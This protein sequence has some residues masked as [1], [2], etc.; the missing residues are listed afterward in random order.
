MASPSFKRTSV[1]I[2]YSHIDARFFDQLVEHLAYFERNN[3]LKV[4]SD[5]KIT[6]GAQWREEI[7]QA[8]EYTAVAV[9]LIS[10]SYL[11]SMFIADNELPPLLH[12]AEKEGAIILPVLV[13]SSYFEDTEL[14]NFQA[15]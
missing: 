5:K 15:V 8:I 10:P 4:W 13:R 3:L 11:A 9:L 12:A 1:F 2:S 14:A 6:P 7:R